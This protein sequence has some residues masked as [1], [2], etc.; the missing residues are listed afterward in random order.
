MKNE[1]PQS[2]PEARA[3]RASRVFCT[4]MALAI[5]A[6]GFLAA[7]PAEAQNLLPPPAAQASTVPS[8]GDV[9]PYGVAF[10]PPTVPTDGLLRHGSILVSNFNNNQ[11]LQGLG[12]T[13]VQI[14][15]QGQTS[16]FFTAT[17]KGQTGLSAAL[18][19]L[20]NGIVIAGYLPSTDGTSQ[21]AGPGGLLF[22]DRKGVLLGSVTNTAAFNGPWGMAV[23]DPGKGLAEI[24][25]SNVESGTITRFLVSYNGQG[26]G[27][28]LSEVTTIGSGFMH[29]GDPAAFEVGPSGLAYNP[30]SD[31]LYVASEVDS[32]IYEIAHAS[33]ITGT[34]GTGTLLVQDTTHLHGPLDLALSPN[35]HLLVANSDGRNADPNQPSELVEYSAAGKFLTQFSVDPNNGG[36]FG[37]AIH[38]LGNGVIRYAAVD[39]NQNTLNMWTIILPRQDD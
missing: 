24:F 7:R 28:Q 32:A 6:A 20:A 38:S 33:T 17:G 5:V 19:I 29:S 21:T 8:N 13:I 18:G 10:V 23:V 37:L 39:D 27:A 2:L 14:S 30:Q 3:H 4:P 15:P 25:V 1:K 22:I 26:E 16:L 9:N 34:A 11:N 31:V 12:T 36:A 35:G